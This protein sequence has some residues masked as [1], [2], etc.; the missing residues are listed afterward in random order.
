MSNW[1]DMDRDELRAEGGFVRMECK[2]CWR[3]FESD[4]PRLCESCRLHVSTVGL[5]YG[6]EDDGGL[7]DQQQDWKDLLERVERSVRY[8]QSR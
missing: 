4:G 2:E 3:V 7:D 8:E 5:S 1:L 6:E